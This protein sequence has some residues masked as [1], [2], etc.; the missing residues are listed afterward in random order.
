MGKIVYM[1]IKPASGERPLVDALQRRNVC[2]VVQRGKWAI[3]AR[4]GVNKGSLIRELNEFIEFYT[5]KK[6]RR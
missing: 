1:I 5:H 3:I 2:S 6:G 4:Y